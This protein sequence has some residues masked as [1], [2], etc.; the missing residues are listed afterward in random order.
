MTS[1]SSNDVN[2]NFNDTSFALYESSLKRLESANLAGVKMPYY[3]GKG[4]DF[5]W[6]EKVLKYK[7]FRNNL[8]NINPGK[9][10]DRQQTEGMFYKTVL[11]NYKRV[12]LKD[13]TAI[14]GPSNEQRGVRSML[15]SLLWTMFDP[16]VEKYWEKR[17]A[18]APGLDITAYPPDADDEHYQEDPYEWDLSSL[19]G[20]GDEN[21]EDEDMEVEEDEEGESDGEAHMTYED[22]Q[23]DAELAGDM[24]D[25]MVLGGD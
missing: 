21:G 17:A 23:D 15:T 19:R 9:I 10:L 20:S 8:N 4:K 3:K 14:F 12:T 2:L 5:F 18:L 6:L 1:N 25:K 13:C 24:E 11:K 22:E 7:G 16:E